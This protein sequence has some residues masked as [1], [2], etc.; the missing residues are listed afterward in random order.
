MR[1]RRR[2]HGAV[3]TDGLLAR[4]RAAPPHPDLAGLDTL[5]MMRDTPSGI[6]LRARSSGG[7]WSVALKLYGRDGAGRATR[8][9]DQ[10]RRAHALLQGNPAFA[11]PEPLAALD[12]PPGYAMRYVGGR[13]GEV[14]LRRTFFHRQRT[15]ERLL[16]RAARWLRAYHLASGLH[17]APLAPGPFL[18]NLQRRLDPTE[19]PGI[20]NRDA[21]AAHLDLLR[22]TL[23]LVR[24]QPFPV[25]AGHGDF[26]LQNLIFDDPVTWS[27]DFSHAAAHP[28]PVTADVACCLFFLEFRDRWRVGTRAGSPGGHDARAIAIFAEAYPE[29]PWNSLETA[30]LLQQQTLRYWAGPHAHRTPDRAERLLAAAEA[31]AATLRDRAALAARRSK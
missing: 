4:L 14:I 21:F 1:F 25:A 31:G 17:P 29:L 24:R 28:V 6:T 15:S 19:P 11:V 26:N 9:L 7:R 27:I 16:D 12:D 3:S 10:H 5:E 30:W 20:V 8:C 18:A 22:E 13:S 2:T 23:P